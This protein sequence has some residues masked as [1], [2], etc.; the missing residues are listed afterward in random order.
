MRFWKPY[1]FDDSINL[2]NWS[3]D[4]ANSPLLKPWLFQQLLTN[5]YWTIHIY[6]FISW[7]CWTNINKS[8]LKTYHSINFHDLHKMFFLS[9]I[10]TCTNL[11]FWHENCV[12]SDSIK[13]C[14]NCLRIYP[15]K[16]ISFPN[17]LLLFLDVEHFLSASFYITCGYIAE[18]GFTPII[19]LYV[20]FCLMTFCSSR[21]NTKESSIW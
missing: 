17:V 10:L 6:S 14:P 2:T 16:E 9:L 15:G 4:M 12:C 18:R 3:L 8:K 1:Q 21:K 20:S 13:Q 11:S 5:F 19:S 7:N